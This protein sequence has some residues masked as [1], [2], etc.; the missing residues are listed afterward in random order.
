MLDIKFI[1]ESKAH[2]ESLIIHC[3]YADG[4]T[5]P[6]AIASSTHTGIALKAGQS[7]LCDGKSLHV[8]VAESKAELNYEKAGKIIA[9][10]M[11]EY[12]IR[13]AIIDVNCVP[14]DL[15]LLAFGVGQR[16]WKFDKYQTSAPRGRH[17]IHF[18]AQDHNTVHKYFERYQALLEGIDLAKTLAA[19]PANILY[20]EAF[21]DRIM[22]L[23]KLGITMHV[24]DEV[25]LKSLNMNAILA[26]SQG[27]AKKPFVVVME[28]NA[29]AV[30]EE[31]VVFVGKG[32]CFDSG[33]LFIK[34]QKMMPYMKHDKAGAAAVVGGM[35]AIAQQKLPVHVVGIIGLVE[36]MPDG[37][38]QKPGDVIV[39]MSSKTIEIADP[40][41]EGR[42]VL[43]DCLWYASQ[44]YKIKRMVSLATLTGETVAC[45]ASEYAGLFTRDEG[46][47]QDLLESGNKSGEKV[48]RLP[49]GDVFK[50]Q[51]K[52]DIADVKNLG[53]LHAGEN[54]AA[55]EFLHEFIDGV[56]YAHLDIAGVAWVD[57]DGIDHAKGI[58]GYGVKLLESFIY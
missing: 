39:S 58:T 21:V 37:N 26:V 16:L 9:I 57:E 20:P 1:S 23:E 5:L 31:P 2:S 54:A 47:A 6:S 19:E 49:L 28:Y 45:L 43:A 48:W 52:S 13:D 12:G 3:C 36:N 25:Q 7:I 14:E 46:L 10:A 40:D 38:A 55:A 51:I 17:T 24:L 50:K 18:I 35:F 44:H 29:A 56:K 8:C 33:G 15:A 4:A 42:L 22:F 30:G 32:V 34:D 11:Q 41:A 53:T 27:S